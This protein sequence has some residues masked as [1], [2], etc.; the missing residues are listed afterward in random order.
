MKCIS[1]YHDEENKK[2]FQYKFNSSIYPTYMPPISINSASTK[3]S[4]FPIL[5]PQKIP[6]IMLNTRPS[7]PINIDIESSLRRQGTK[8][9]IGNEQNVYIPNSTSSMYSS[10]HS[11]NITKPCMSN[12]FF[13]LHQNE[14]IV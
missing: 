7:I 5:E 12:S 14:R 13:K 11:S 9:A 8:Y 4:Y 2:A 10:F 6:S 1:E 3:Y